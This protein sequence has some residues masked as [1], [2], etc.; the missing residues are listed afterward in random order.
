M[1]W[2]E[3]LRYGFHRPKCAIGE[4]SSQN[5]SSRKHVSSVKHTRSLHISR[6]IIGQ[7]LRQPLDVLEGKVKIWF[8]SAQVC[9][10]GNFFAESFNKESC[11]FSKAHAF[12]AHF[13]A[14]YRSMAQTAL[15]CIGGKS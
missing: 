6:L 12:T 2:R 11:I 13:P 5:H 14:Y 10:W 15:G 9:D 1:Y 4:I 3:K 8:S 7:W